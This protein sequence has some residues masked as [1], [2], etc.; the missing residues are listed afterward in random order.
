MVETRL[1]EKRALADIVEELRIR[2]EQH[3]DELKGHVESLDARFS[4][5][6]SF[7]FIHLPHSSAQQQQPQE[8]SPTPSAMQLSPSSSRPPDPPDRPGSDQIRAE[9]SSA[10]VSRQYPLTNSLSSRLTKV[11][12]PMFNGSKLREWIYRC[13]QFFGLDHTPIEQRVPLASMHLEDEALEWHH[14]FIAERYGILPS[15]S[16][17]VVDISARFS[18]IVNDPLSEL[19]SLKQGSDSIDVYLKKFESA[20]TRV[21]LTA[22]HA[23]SIFFTNMQP[24]LSL[25]VRQFAVTSI[26]EAAR[27]AKL[28]EA[29]LAQT[30]QRALRAPFNPLATPKYS[31]S[32]LSKG[33]SSSP[34]L[35]LPD[36]SKLYKAIPTPLR[37]GHFL[38]KAVNFLTEGPY[39]ADRSAADQRDW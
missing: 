33:P 2:Q 18:G 13:D 16:D 22:A 24:H 19:V 23:L 31:G 6:E 35:L 39:P 30:P 4:K 8:P 34:L 38:S 5:L 28:H 36:T 27:I 26:S 12:F 1:Q 14:N 25:H 15:W 37:F 3:S 11:G 7:L 32:P 21:T 10:D 9:R 17:Y 20:R 29:A